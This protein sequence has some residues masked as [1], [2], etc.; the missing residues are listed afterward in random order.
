MDDKIFIAAK[1]AFLIYEQLQN[2][3]RNV[4]HIS[5][6]DGIAHFIELFNVKTEEI[7]SVL[8]NDPAML[9]TISFLKPID[10]NVQQSEYPSA[11]IDGKRGQFMVI[12]G[13]LMTA[14]RNFM[15]FY[16]TKEDQEKFGLTEAFFKQE[17]GQD[18][19]M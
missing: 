10:T 2:M 5:S 13:V 12:S 1:Q 14:L 16:L 15:R 17:Q 7:N 8:A 9:E 4:R 6:L 11:I 18:S 19:T 3:R